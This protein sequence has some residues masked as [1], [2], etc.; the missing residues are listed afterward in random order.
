MLDLREGNG[1][2]HWVPVGTGTT[3]C[4]HPHSGA[5]P[6]NEVPLC[7]PCTM[8]HEDIFPNATIHRSCRTGGLR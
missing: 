7:I 1:V 4:G 2:A 8:R 5:I 3:L 6:G